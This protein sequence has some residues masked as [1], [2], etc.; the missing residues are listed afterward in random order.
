MQRAAESSG[1]S[2]SDSSGDGDDGGDDDGDV[3][4]R[5][6][7]GDS[8]ESGSA[9]AKR[10]LQKVHWPWCATEGDKALLS[11]LPSLVRMFSTKS[12]GF[13]FPEDGDKYA[14]IKIADAYYLAS[15]VGVYVLMQCKGVSQEYLTA[16]ANHLYS[17]DAFLAPTHVKDLSALSDQDRDKWASEG[18]LASKQR[19]VD[20]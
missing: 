16:F 6:D 11:S 18:D 10:K 13:M 12:G 20:R 5:S 4:G 2:D 15:S 9:G 1:G 3:D 8:S 7:G 17:L 19:E 14:D